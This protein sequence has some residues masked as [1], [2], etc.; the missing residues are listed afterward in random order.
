[1]NVNGLGGVLSPPGCETPAPSAAPQRA[2]PSSPC[3]LRHALPQVAPPKP[4]S[5]WAEDI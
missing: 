3:T 1:M 2:G 4:P 5:P